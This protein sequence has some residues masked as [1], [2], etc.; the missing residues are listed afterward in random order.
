MIGK[1][2]L[3]P[4]SKEFAPPFVLKGALLTDIS[5]DSGT[6]LEAYRQTGGV[7]TFERLLQN[8]STKKIITDLDKSK[9]RGRAGGGYPV[10]HKWW[11]VQNDKS[12]EK[13]FICNANS[14]APGGFK[15]RFLINLN[16][17]RIVEAVA[18]G[19]L[20]V[21]AETA[22]IA[23]PATLRAEA[24]L[25]RKAVREFEENNLL[26]KNIL[27]SGKN[28][29][30]IIFET[31]GEYILGEETALMEIMQGRIGQPTGK[32]PLPSEKGLFG[33][34]TCVNNLETVLQAH[35]VLKKGVRNFQKQ[36][37]PNA[38]GTVITCLSGNIRRPGIY[39]IPLGTSVKELIY[40]LG[41][42][43]AD[44]AAL[45]GVLPGGAGSVI[46]REDEIDIGF[47]YDSLRDAG[48]DAGSGTVI[49]V[50]GKNDVVN[51][52]RNLSSFLYDVS[53]GKCLPC[54]QGTY[55]TKVLL[56]NLDN[57][58]AKSIDRINN[59]LPET[60]RVRSL[61][62]IQPMGGIS[63]TDTVEASDKIPHLCEFFKYRGDCHH[64]YEAASSIQ[65]LYNKFR[66]EFDS[67]T[68]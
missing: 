15:E 41:Q 62:V 44:D 56:E 60:K 40:D 3:K 43:I 4:I 5:A 7:K 33:K 52:S 22:I 2:K 49:V 26:G 1:N 39:E 65:T 23:L 24:D 6:S 29:N 59:A 36:G 25:L 28:I 30:L 42:G 35:F 51:L 63:Y 20:A 45:L 16:P 66:T 8:S 11:L 9:L 67:R 37:I 12:P 32:P 17:Y 61:N 50:S 19:A 48:S 46:L 13:F 38:Y 55:R 53:C 31:P 21:G 54:K 18:T 58:D 68:V 14:G 57:L 27:E 64:S 34:P 47:D 10:A